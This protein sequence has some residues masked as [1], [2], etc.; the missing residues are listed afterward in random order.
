[1]VKRLDG[2]MTFHITIQNLRE[3]Y[4]LCMKYCIVFGIV[5]IMNRKQCHRIPMT[6]IICMARFPNCNLIE[7]LRNIEYR[8]K[9]W[10]Y[11][12]FD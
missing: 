11:L 2:W 3:T 9:L 5:I 12:C 1:M 6:I 7:M 8:D 4:N 10:C